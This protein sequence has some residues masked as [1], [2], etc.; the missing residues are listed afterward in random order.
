MKNLK[1]VLAD[2]T[3]ATETVKNKEKAEDKLLEV[4]TLQDDLSKSLDSKENQLTRRKQRLDNY[5]IAH[6]QFLERLSNIQK[7]MQASL[8]FNLENIM[9]EELKANDE[10][11]QK[12]ITEMQEMESA[13]ERLSEDASLLLEGATPDEKS[14]ISIKGALAEV[15]KRYQDTLESLTTTRGGTY[16]LMQHIRSTY[17]YI[18]LVCCGFKLNKVPN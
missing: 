14:A 5:T 12:L 10:N 13:M 4:I 7:V 1:D 6:E 11:I 8:D 3:T 16:I 15:K 17:S 18:C 9:T 2:L